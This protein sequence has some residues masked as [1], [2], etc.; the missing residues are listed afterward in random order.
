[1][2]EEAKRRAPT[3]VRASGKVLASRRTKAVVRRQKK[4][5]ASDGGGG[6]ESKVIESFR[7]AVVMVERKV[8]M[9]VVT[10]PA[11]VVSLSLLRGMARSFLS[12]SK[13]YPATLGWTASAQ[14]MGTGAINNNIAVSVV[15]TVLSEFVSFAALFDEFYVKSMTVRF[16]PLS[17]YNS[18]PTAVVGV[19]QTSVPLVSVPLF[20]GASA[21][22][23]MVAAT[24]NRLATVHSSSDAFTAKWT[25]TTSSKDT[26]VVNASTSLATPVQGWCLTSATPA[27]GYTGFIMFISSSALGS[28]SVQTYG[29]YFVKWNLLFRLRA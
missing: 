7:S 20:N 17:R 6:S 18:I 25:N 13:V 14:T 23:S 8:G 27:S 22:S 24:E 10:E 21:Y 15:A 4:K 28:T 9:S 26:V 12:P 16:E 11:P 19:S 29:Q 1:M 2:S 5:G 3:A